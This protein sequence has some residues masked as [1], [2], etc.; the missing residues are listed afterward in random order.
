MPQRYRRPVATF[1]ETFKGWTDTLR[2][3]VDAMQAIIEGAGAELEAR[4]LAAGALS[5]LVMRMDLVPDW[6][7]GI[8]VLDDVMVLRV[9]A[10]L[11]QG[12][13]LGPL[14]GDAEYDLGRMSNEADR[15]TEFLGD[16]IYDKLKVYC[17]R[18]GETAVRGRTPLS[19]VNDET[20][21]KAL[22]TEVEDEL[23][24]NG[25]V[26]IEDPADAEIRLKAYLT[27]KLA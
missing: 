3:D 20:A 14:P 2:Q 13:D 26:V 5:Y 17:A 18:L 12:Y 25:P 9:S 4:K 24:K 10:Q 22:Y 8:G 7:Q 21:R 15:I 11:A 19:V 6:N 16:E 23:K 1:I 27:H